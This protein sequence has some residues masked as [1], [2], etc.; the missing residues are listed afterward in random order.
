MKCL[1][2]II[3]ILRQCRYNVDFQVQW[4][5]VKCKKGLV[6]FFETGLFC[7]YFIILTCYQLFHICAYHKLYTFR[8]GL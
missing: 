1:I 7:K 3:V 2:H 6:H 5:N 4:I 8:L